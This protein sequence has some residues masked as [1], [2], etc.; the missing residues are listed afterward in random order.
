MNCLDELEQ[1][2]AAHNHAI[3]TL[4]WSED[5]EQGTRLG[6]DLRDRISQDWDSFREQAEALGFDAVEHRSTMI[7]RS[8]GDEWDYAA[9][10]FILT[11]NHH[12]AG[13]WDGDWH[14]PWGE[15]LTALALSFPQVET[16]LDDDNILRIF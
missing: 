6:N 9:H 8:Q 1:S 12:G 10:D 7:D 16:Y 2:M 14:A 4:I 5:L 3:Q 11:R 15:K 13:F